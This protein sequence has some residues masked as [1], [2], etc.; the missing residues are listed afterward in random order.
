[1]KS[2]LQLN[3]ILQLLLAGVRSQKLDIDN[4]EGN[5]LKD[6]PCV[7]R[8]NQL[9]CTD[10]GSAYPTER[11]GVFADDNKALLRR[12]FGELQVMMIMQC[13]ICSLC[14]KGRLIIRVLP[15]LGTL[16]FPSNKY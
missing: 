9:Y 4:G 5:V 1:M 6:L 16:L 12:M 3:N 13:Y 14:S 8:F 10:P 11:I 15:N 2:I 7:M